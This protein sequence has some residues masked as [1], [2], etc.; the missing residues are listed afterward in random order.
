MRQRTLFV[1]ILF[2]ILFTA[3]PKAAPDIV[4][5]SRG[6]FVF[7]ATTLQG[8]LN[9]AGRPDFRMTGTVSYAGGHFF[10]YDQCNAND[11]C[12]PGAEVSLEAGWGGLDLHATV[13][14]WD[15]TFGTAAEN[16]GGVIGFSGTATMPALT[17]KRRASV[18]VPFE[19]AGLV[20]FI[21]DDGTQLE[22]LLTGGGTARLDLV[23]GEAGQSWLVERAT[24]KFQQ[25]Q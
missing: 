12:Q 6:T 18:S 8:T 25:L 20:Q 16:G 4:S 14:L 11:A 23:W 5:V 24:Y 17:S 21:Q 1:G 15:Q 13:R 7:D 9:L 3:V 22:A 10:P 2:A 19:F